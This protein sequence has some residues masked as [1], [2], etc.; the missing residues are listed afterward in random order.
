MPKPTLTDLPP[1][2]QLLIAQYATGTSPT[3]SFNISTSSP[4]NL[5]RL[6]SVCTS[7]H[8][9]TRILLSD[10][11]FHPAFQTPTDVALLFRT[12]YLSGKNLR[13]LH[14][15]VPFPLHAS[16]CYLADIAPPLK[17]L[18][19]ISV[20]ASEALIAH[21]LARLNPS[22]THLTLSA[23]P[24]LSD[25]HL[26][27]LSRRLTSLSSFHLAHSSFLTLRALTS[28]FRIIG[29]TLKNLHLESL[30]HPSLTHAA[31]VPI[32]R[33]CK[34]V[35]NLSLLNLPWLTQT[36]L[37]LFQLP[38]SQLDE[39]HLIRFY[40]SPTPSFTLAACAA[41][42]NR[43]F[44]LEGV[45]TQANSPS[46]HTTEYAH[47][48]HEKP[49]CPYRHTHS[50]QPSARQRIVRLSDASLTDSTLS[51]LARN[52][53]PTLHTL[54]LRSSTHLTDISL[55]SISQHSCSIVAL[56][57]SYLPQITD[58]GLAQLLD[59]L[60]LSLLELR[61]VACA[62][63]TDRSVQ[64]NIP[65]FGSRLRLVRLTYSHFSLKAVSA[66]REAL[67]RVTLCGASDR[68]F[69]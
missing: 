56:D 13:A 10:L 5:T 62:G 43:D 18:S 32:L 21:L 55:A 45:F 17:S 16:L 28:F 60:Q 14:L 4:R 57:L 23:L 58:D 67:P 69:L 24:F 12:L 46:L 64:E 66:L 2:L 19:L 48:P 36:S 29:P 65:R 33:P 11:R 37:F 26:A 39:L 31:L 42:H 34:A 52:F 6:S 15:Q 3:L 40:P 7:L 44:H 30:Q 53:G 27:L 68:V 41:R 59:V 1:E 25:R 50:L 35:T 22:L 8:Y 49:T 63:L 51:S 38:I 9:A 47:P 54:S 61:I 20:T